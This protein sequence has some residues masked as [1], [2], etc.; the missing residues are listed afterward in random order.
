MTFR[1]LNGDKIIGKSDFE[2]LDAS[3]GVAQGVFVPSLDYREVQPVFRLYAQAGI[4]MA[5]QDDAK[6]SEY[7]RARDGL[8]LSVT[9]PDGEQIPTDCIH[10]TDYSEEIGE[11]EVAVIV[12][13]SESFDRYFALRR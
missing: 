12:A 10:I 13:D 4:S 1:I 9:S 8:D 11:M 6:L 7:Y 5:D 2:V 3:M